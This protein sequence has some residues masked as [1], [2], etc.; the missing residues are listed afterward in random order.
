MGKIDAYSMLAGIPAPWLG[1]L[2]YS[3]FGFVA[4]LAVYLVCV[5]ISAPIVFTLKE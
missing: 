3:K 5:I 4:P 1:G 2:L